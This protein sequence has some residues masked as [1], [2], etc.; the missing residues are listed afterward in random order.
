[1]NW[2]KFTK[3][4][5]KK[6]KAQCFIDYGRSYRDTI[7][8]VGSGRSGTTWLSDVINY[9]ENYRYIFEPFHNQKVHACRK[10]VAQTYIRPKDPSPHNHQL[11]QKVLSGRVRS[12]WSDRFNEKILSHQRLIKSIRVNLLLKWLTLYFPG[13]PVVYLMRH[14]F[15]VAV[16]RMKYGGWRTKGLDKYLSQPEL[17]DDFLE[18]FRREMKLAKRKYQ[19]TGDVFDNHIFSWCIQNYIP[20][21]QC[22]ANDFHIVF[23]EDCCVEPA[24]E[25][26]RLFNYLKKKPKENILNGLSKASRVSRRDS[27]IVTGNSL[28]EG[29]KNSLSIKQIERGLEILNLF[30]LD[31]IYSEDLMPRAEGLS[32][33]VQTSVVC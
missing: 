3:Q 33:F 6:I 12:N 8:L 29:W 20:L 26:S 32:N 16:S 18:P 14:P 9:N 1:M 19:A 28:I 13:M 27:A 4:Q 5:L 11:F 31:A 15:A 7:L 2:T 30:G 10:F 25:I 24:C 17:M 22:S 23:Y 21:R